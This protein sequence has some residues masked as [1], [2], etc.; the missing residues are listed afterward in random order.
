MDRG[1]LFAD[2]VYEV[3]PVYAGRPFR[4]KQHLE[5]LQ[6][7]LKAIRLSQPSLDSRWEELFN[8]L[9]RQNNVQQGSLY[10]QVTRG[11][12]PRRD[13]RFAGEALPTVFIK[14]DHLLPNSTEAQ[15]ESEG[16]KVITVDDFRWQR[17]DIKSTGL[18]AN[19]LARQMADDESASEAIFVAD[20]YIN[21]GSASNVFIVEHGV[22]KTPPLSNNI[23]GGITRDLVL[24]MAANNGWATKQSSIHLRQLYSADEV[25]LTS[26][27]REIQPVIQV[28][29]QFIGDG[30]VGPLWRKIVEEFADF[31]RRLFS[32]DWR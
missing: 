29:E 31:K 15:D 7:S 22:I 2:S 6:R 3:I 12:P 1:F 10:L 30:T 28:D 24:E 19:C 21:E 23:L 13:H 16:L 17:C 9:I 11:C 8:E 14:A 4:V 25:W 5:R 27:S 32:G 18:L 20:E 26:S